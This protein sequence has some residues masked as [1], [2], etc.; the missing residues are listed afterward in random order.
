MS[1]VVAAIEA[2]V[3]GA[4]IEFDDVQLPF[5]EQLEAI[6]L[7]HVLGPLEQTP[8]EQGVRET[9]EYFGRAPA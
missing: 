2:A 7:E 3:P 6:A 8:I 5:P 4:K 9:I 1:R